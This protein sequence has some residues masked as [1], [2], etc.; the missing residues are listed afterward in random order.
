GAEGLAEASGGKQTI[1]SVLG[2]DQN[3]IEITGQAAMLEG[4]IKKV[5]LWAEFVFGEAA[6]RITIFANN[7]WD[8]QPTSNE[9]RLIT[10][11]TSRPGRINEQ[12]TARAASVAAGENIELYSALFEQ[13]AK[14]QDKR[15]FTGTAHGQ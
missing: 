3:D 8:V 1:A 13:L 4:V 5:Q 7:D 15:C 2:R 6:G 14:E 11:F 9:Y 10:E 12:Y